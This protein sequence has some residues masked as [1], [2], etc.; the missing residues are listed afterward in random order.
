MRLRPLFLAACLALALPGLAETLDWDACVAETKAHNVDLVKA[1]AN[2][3]QSRLALIDS[4][5][6]YLPKL[7]LSASGS[8]SG[9]Y[10]PQE[11]TFGSA[12]GG[13]APAYGLGLSAS[14]NLF[15]GFSTLN[16][17]AA[18]RARLAEAEVGLRQTRASVAFS[19]REA[20][21]QMLFAQEQIGM[22]VDI[23]ARRKENVGLVSLR[24]EAGR[25][26]KGSLLETKA[27]A[28]QAVYDANRATRELKSSAFRLSQILGR[29]PDPA[30]RVRGD[31][32]SVSVPAVPD[33]KALAPTLP[34]ALKARAQVDEA[35]ASLGGE[36]S[37]FL[38]SLNANASL[39]R[40]GYSGGAWP[41]Q[42]GSWSAGLSLSWNLFNGFSD[43][44]QSAA[45][46]SRSKIAELALEDT[47][48]QAQI[49][50]EQAY[51]SLADAAES[52]EV[53]A[54]F[55]ES[56]QT[57]AEIGRAQY[58]QGLLNF[59]NWNQIE[60]NLIVARKQG[61]SSRR[62]AVD[63]RAGWERALGKGFEP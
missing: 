7:G 32:E 23:A 8:S 35:K 10:D 26:N 45:A 5:S 6:G 13:G 18:A 61:L 17:A 57:R 27:Q 16:S 51:E 62:D 22:S 47:L 14:Q 9:P 24:F 54:A 42:S 31:L 44:M 33:T 50:L 46:R 12:T 28:A 63:A 36:Y 4:L 15:A 53:R 49:D 52:A 25:E 34:P 58:T 60:S 39:N 1:E 21:D 38:P 43:S 3:D 2:V 59:D 30:L 19:L 37:G 11:G 56:S 41:P 55:L 29:L 20:F 48:R 40:S